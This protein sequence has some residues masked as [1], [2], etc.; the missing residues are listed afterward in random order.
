MSELLTAAQAP[1]LY[2]GLAIV[3][4]F[5]PPLAIR[6]LVLVYPRG[7]LRR[8]ELPAEMAA[9]PYRNRP[10]WLAEQLALV[11]TEGLAERLRLRPLLAIHF[12]DW[13]MAGFRL[14]MAVGNGLLGVALNETR[15]PGSAFP[16]VV[17]AAALLGSVLWEA[18]RAVRLSGRRH[19]LVALLLPRLSFSEDEESPN[20]YWG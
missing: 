2:V 16:F 9:V 14:A 8:R 4:G 7:H 1:W 13:R 17:A 3:F 12:F 20:A 18:R 6:L 11:L 15:G 5:C 10:L 19:E